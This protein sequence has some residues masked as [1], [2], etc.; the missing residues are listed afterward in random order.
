MRLPVT[1]IGGNFGG[2]G[3]GFIHLTD[4]ALLIE[5]ES[6]RFRL[7]LVSAIPQIA[8]ILRALV[9][10]RSV[11]TVPYSTIAEYRPG[12]EEQK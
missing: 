8:G 3:S 1:R 4:T 2:L 5:G 9:C 7:P 6:P 10:D 11:R 12:A